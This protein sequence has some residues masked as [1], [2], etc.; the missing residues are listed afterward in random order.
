MV[1]IAKHVNLCFIHVELG[2]PLS[3]LTFALGVGTVPAL[4]RKFLVT[5]TALKIMGFLIELE[6]A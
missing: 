1:D 5:D 6:R 3:P 2:L 4:A